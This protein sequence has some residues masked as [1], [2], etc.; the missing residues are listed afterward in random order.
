MAIL[1]AQ[2]IRKLCLDA[3][4]TEDTKVHLSDALIVPFNE[5]SVSDGMTWGLGPCTYDFCIQQGLV[6]LP[7]WQLP[8]LWFYWAVDWMLIQLG[9]SPL[10]DHYHCS[11]VLVSTI[12]RVKFPNDICGTVMDK[13]SWA[14]R[15]LAVQ[16]TKFDPGF[17]GYPTLEL[18]NHGLY[19]IFIPAGAPICQFK[20]E[21]LEEPTDM[22]YTGR[23]QG[24]DSKPTPYRPAKGAWE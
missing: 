5:R 15:G 4:S 3:T 8:R 9:M 12:E 24:Q 6:L 10:H 23:Y 14:R 2:T 18:S 21:R 11:F 13:S 16:N 20:F 17:E 1:P 7:M 22:P 19:A